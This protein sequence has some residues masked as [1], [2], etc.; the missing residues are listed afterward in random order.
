MAAF[1]TYFG[2]INT[3]DYAAAYNVFSPRLRSGFT[4][5]SFAN[6]DATSYDSEETVLAAHTIDST[7]VQVALAFTSLQTPDN[8]PNR[9]TCD[10]WTL[11]YTM[12]E[13]SDGAWLIDRTQ[14]YHGV[15]HTSC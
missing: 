13:G 1:N 11:T 3:G 4:E 10:N 8:G 15:S 7:T 6:G 9:D 2:G 12:I 14:P 5:Q